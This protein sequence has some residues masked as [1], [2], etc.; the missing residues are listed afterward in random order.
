VEPA[1][2]LLQ[3][4]P[5]V[6]DAELDARCHNVSSAPASSQMPRAAKSTGV[7]CIVRAVRMG[8]AST[9]NH[10]VARLLQWISAADKPNTTNLVGFVLQGGVRIL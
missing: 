1:T 10:H 6:V 2:E 5:D 8:S 7:R 9:G 3:Q 4:R